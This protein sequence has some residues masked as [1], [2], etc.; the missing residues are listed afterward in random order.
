MFIFLSY[1]IDSDAPIYGGKTGFLLR[2]A[3]SI[4]NGNNANT[5]KWELPNH[6]GTHIDFPYHF[7]E[8]GQ[9]S[10]FF[11][12]EFWIFDGVKIQVLEVSLSEK[13]FLIE[14]EHIERHN[15][16]SDADFL[17]LKTGFGK[18][19]N[20]EKFWKYNPGISVETA[21]WIIKNFK[22]IRVIGID[23]ISISSWQHRDIGRKVHKKLL[24]PKNPILII[25]DMDLS[26]VNRDTIFKMIYV[27]PLM[28]S[29]SDGVPLT[30]LAEVK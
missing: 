23:S 26:K 6:L 10:D 18:Y 4:K 20:K 24:N 7:Y 19:R 30:I 15:F 12:P 5:Q 8:N 28:V 22:K 29:S 1:K 3:S 2:T 14:P 9:T 27:S 25:E 13:K 16:N 21:E 11:P 17:I